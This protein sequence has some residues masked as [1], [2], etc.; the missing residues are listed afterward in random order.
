MRICKIDN[1]VIDCSLVGVDA[2]GFGRALA[3]E[4]AIPFSLKISAEEV[5]TYFGSYYQEFVDRE[6]EDEGFLEELEGWALLL[7][8]TGYL[9]LEK[10]LAEQPE[11]I[12]ELLLN[13]LSAEFMG[14]LFLDDAPALSKKYILQT[15]VTLEVMGG[16]V[17]CK[18]MAFINPLFP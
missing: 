13:E 17:H 8:E 14:Y 7:K 11:L 5:V 6:S 1:D 10:I 15:L 16:E 12:S 2:H 4:C 3:S 18:G 9:S